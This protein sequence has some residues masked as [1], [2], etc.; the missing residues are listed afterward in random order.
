[1]LPSLGGAME[2]QEKMMLGLLFRPLSQSRFSNQIPPTHAFAAFLGGGGQSHGHGSI[3]RRSDGVG[4]SAPYHPTGSLPVSTAAG[5]AAAVADS[6]AAASS[7]LALPAV[8]ATGRDV[9]AT[10]LAVPPSGEVPATGRDVV[11]MIVDGTRTPDTMNRAPSNSELGG[12]VKR[13]FSSSEET[14]SPSVQMGSKAKAHRVSDKPLP[15]KEQAELDTDAAL[16]AHE[17]TAAHGKVGRNNARALQ[18]T[19][20]ALMKSITRASARGED[21]SFLQAKANQLGLLIRYQEAKSMA[22]DE[23]DFIKL[24]RDMHKAGMGVNATLQKKAWRRYIEFDAKQGLLLGAQACKDAPGDIGESEFKQLIL[25]RCEVESGQEFEDAFFKADFEA[26]NVESLPPEW[27]Q[28]LIDF[29]NLRPGCP[30]RKEA[31]CAFATGTSS[32]HK[33]LLKNRCCAAFVARVSQEEEAREEEKASGATLDTVATVGHA[34]AALHALHTELR[35]A[36]DTPADCKDLLMSQTGECMALVTAS[37]CCVASQQ[38]T[39]AGNESLKSLFEE[40]AD[41]YDKAGFSVVCAQIA[42][43][44]SKNPADS[45][46]EKIGLMCECTSKLLEAVERAFKSLSSPGASATRISLA[47]AMIAACKKSASMRWWCPQAW[48]QGEAPER[49][50]WLHVASEVSQSL[51]AVLV[52]A[53]ALGPLHAT[54]SDA[55]D[56]MGVL[57]AIVDKEIDVFHADAVF[58]HQLNGTEAAKAAQ[59]LIQ[60]IDLGTPEKC[61]V[62]SAEALSVVQKQVDAIMASVQSLASEQLSYQ[63]LGELRV[64]E[65]GWKLVAALLGMIT[66][67]G[68]AQANAPVESWSCVGAVY[69]AFQKF[70]AGM[71]EYSG[72]L[73]Q[74]DFW[75]AMAGAMPQHIGSF[76]HNRVDQLGELVDRAEQAGHKA[77]VLDLIRESRQVDVGGIKDLSSKL[78]V[79]SAEEFAELLQNHSEVAWIEEKILSLA[80]ASVTAVLY[81][82]GRDAK[83]TGAHTL[84]RTLGEWFLLKAAIEYLAS[85]ERPETDRNGILALLN[86]TSVTLP[87]SWAAELGVPNASSNEVTKKEA[88][89]VT[90]E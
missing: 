78:T 61:G 31:A 7:M 74:H 51:G 87:D 36:V 84:R 53:H 76:Y 33:A 29:H 73:A 48:P 64:E 6:A 35:K 66:S 18:K 19:R 67:R 3:H 16:A 13:E 11:P 60:E 25:S 12:S 58:L 82:G 40:C 65:L 28:V 1:M 23:E 83:I 80:D 54:T 2:D 4:R 20:D 47:A 72:D 24:A 56:R 85:L 77:K 62:K 39:T 81:E 34:T 17:A 71:K 41:L 38:G 49:N 45:S 75:E 68:S 89:K 9:T 26:S 14:T 32:L 59:E 37:E 27:Q 63:R 5:A 88:S 46:V 10:R 90:A 50:Q 79:V 43:N 42:L 86:T 15:P 69:N 52:Q 21:T 70:K 22:G 44:V 57:L 8:H 30:L 55:L